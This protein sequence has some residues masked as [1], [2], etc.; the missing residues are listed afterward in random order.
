MSLF[1]LADCN[2]FYASCERVFDPALEGRP[3]VV[4]SN[5]DGC[6]VARSNEAKALGIPMGVPFF[7]VKPLVR[8]HGVAV[9][10]SNYSLYGD[11]SRR[12][13]TILGQF[14]PDL[15]IY[16]ID[17]AFL[18]LDRMPGP[19]EALALRLRD[20]VLQCTGIPISIGIG[21]SKTLA[22]LANH[23]AKRVTRAP[24]YRIQSL[25]A[26]SALFQQLPVT[27]VWGIGRR[28][29]QQ[30]ESGLRIRTVEELRRADPRLIRAHL[31]VLGERIVRELNGDPCLDLES[32]QTN[33]QIICSKS[34]CVRV[35]ELPLLAQAVSNYAARACV[36]LRRQQLMAGGVQVFLQTG[37]HD[38][39]PYSNALALPLPSPSADS[40]HI[41]RLA[42]WLLRRIFRPG[43]PYQKAGV[44]LLDLASAREPRQL[45][46]FNPSRDNPR[47]MQAIDGIN[48]LLG[49][50]QVFI[51]AQGM[52]RPWQM[53]MAHRSP[54]YTTCWEEL[55]RV[56]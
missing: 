36:K 22:K 52:Q 10:S 29:A 7:Q 54:R 4:L 41:I 28:F 39:K 27:E 49:T 44:M 25:E 6:V 20:R 1:A 55:P 51:A 12:V 50:D 18:R 45:D 26:E 48:R 24:V 56:V 42:K 9:L 32:I 2:N 14:C 23:I 37:L 3:I 16:S 34:F 33:Q 40:R 8:R 38:P 35:Q 5:N 13:M 19:P 43:Y 47:L 17:E 21:P 31:S 11:L 53:R 15:E 30:L 46:L